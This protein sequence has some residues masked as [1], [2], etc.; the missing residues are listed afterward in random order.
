MLSLQR[1]RSC[2]LTV[3]RWCLVGLDLAYLFLGLAAAKENKYPASRHRETFGSKCWVGAHI[4]LGAVVIYGGATVFVLDN[5][6]VSLQHCTG[7]LR[8]IAIS[9]VLH[10]ITV[11][12]MLKKVP[13]CRKVTVPYYV[14]VTV[15]NL[16]TAIQVL[17]TPSVPNLMLLW[18]AVSAFVYVRFFV[19]VFHIVS[20]GADFMVVY[21]L[22]MG[23]A[24]YFATIVNGLN[25]L[26]LLIIITPV[27]VAPV[28][29]LYSRWYHTRFAGEIMRKC[30]KCV[31][32]DD[33][34]RGHSGG[35][36][37]SVCTSIHDA[38]NPV[39][40]PHQPS[41]KTGWY[42]TLLLWFA[43]D[44]LASANRVDGNKFTVQPQDA[45]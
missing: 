13:G 24:G 33:A 2:D 15:I 34:A 26:S 43:A 18:G 27:F 42:R 22:A 39:D 23:L 10:A 8:F 41:F 29:V 25:S 38:F 17:C 44:N 12:G 5:Q 7:V 37:F 28:M 35:L 21:T 14:G 36:L 45:A 4:L 32:G 3:Y 1:M 40:V 9:A 16:Y 30:Q 6:S 11:S 19:F 31:V 20:G